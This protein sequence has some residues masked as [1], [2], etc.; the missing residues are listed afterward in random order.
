MPLD[1]KKMLEEYVS[2]GGFT[3]DGLC[4]CF[5]LPC[6]LSVREAAFQTKWLKSED[7][8]DNM[9]TTVVNLKQAVRWAIGLPSE[10]SSICGG[11]R[12]Q[13]TVTCPDADAQ[14]AH[15]LGVKQC[16]SRKRKKGRG[17]PRGLHPGE[18]SKHSVERKLLDIRG[19]DTLARAADEWFGGGC[20]GG[21]VM[22]LNVHTRIHVERDPIL[23]TG[24]YR[25][26]SRCMP[27]SPWVSNY[28]NVVYCWYNYGIQPINCIF[29]R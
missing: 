26:L 19:T 18:L 10:S 28:T 12:A 23:V 21:S 6:A 25:K 4:V 17:G 11:L 8:M 20:D 9:R 2:E 27:Q 13:V 1:M 5:A 3:D 14:V 7:A 29:Y 16:T 22:R 15:M 24:R